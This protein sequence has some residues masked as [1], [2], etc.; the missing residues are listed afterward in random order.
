[1]KIFTDSEARR[2][3][4]EVLDI[5]RTEGVIIQRSVGESY[6][7]TFK[8]NSKTPFDVDGLDTGATT[9]DILG[10]IRESR[11]GGRQS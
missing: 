6:S 9:D 10:A 7:V 11:S 3:L 1:M 5:A 2:R 4:S 8:K